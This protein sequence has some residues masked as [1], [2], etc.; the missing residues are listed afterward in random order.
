LL[1]TPSNGQDVI[2]A[3]QYAGINTG[4]TTGT[5]PESD[6]AFALFAGTQSDTVAGSTCFFSPTAADWAAVQQALNSG[7]TQVPNLGTDDPGCYSG[8]TP[9]E[10]II[11]RA[12]IR[13]NASGSGAPAFL[14]ERQ[15]SQD[16]DPAVVEI[17]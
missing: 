2:V 1:P 9:S 8:S 10:Q 12:S 15:K 16:T 17:P 4:I 11:Y 13:N 7:T 5:T 14:F 3:S 6:L